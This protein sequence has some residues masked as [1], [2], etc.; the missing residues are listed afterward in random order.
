MRGQ[1]FKRIW[2]PQRIH[3]YSQNVTKKRHIH[4]HSHENDNRTHR[5]ESELHSLSLALCSNV[6]IA[7]DCSKLYA[8]KHQDLFNDA[9]DG[10]YAA[11]AAVV[12]AFLFSM[13]W[14]DTCSTRFNYT[15]VLSMHVCVCV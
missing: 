12:V 13:R 3:T 10:L 7:R 8:F 9:N 11:A 2:K 15:Y 14:I 6:Y 4:K 1:E 5:A